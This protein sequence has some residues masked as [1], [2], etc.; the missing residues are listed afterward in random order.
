MLC[1]KIIPATDVGLHQ[2]A[3]PPET[4]IAAQIEAEK[5]LNQARRTRCPNNPGD[6]HIG[7]VECISGRLSFEVKLPI[8]MAEL[9]LRRDKVLVPLVRHQVDP[10]LVVRIGPAGHQVE[11]EELLPVHHDARVPMKLEPVSLRSGTSG[12]ELREREIDGGR[13]QHSCAEGNP[14]VPLHVTD[15]TRQRE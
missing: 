15:S 9:R 12:P 4:P 11:G 1:H 8:I 7:P 2:P 14:V 13:R 3:L 10:E 6:D 5:L